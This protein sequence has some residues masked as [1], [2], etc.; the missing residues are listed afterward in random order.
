MLPALDEST[1]QNIAGRGSRAVLWM[2]GDADRRSTQALDPVV[3]I[4]RLH[5]EQRTAR[6]TRA[7]NTFRRCHRRH[8]V[9]RMLL[10]G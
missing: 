10:A 8:L 5:I 4:P 1:L 7:I 2:T 6:K 3:P 9:S